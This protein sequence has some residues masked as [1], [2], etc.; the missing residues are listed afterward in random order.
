[1]KVAGTNLSR[2]ARHGLLM[3]GA[4]ALTL[5]AAAAAH[6]QDTAPASEPATEA[7]REVVVTGSRIRGATL[8]SPS[9]LQ[10]VT[11]ETIENAGATNVQ[12]V[13]TQIPAVGVP[14]QTRVSN[15]GDTSPGLSTVNLRNLGDNRTLVLIDGRRSV[16][17][18]PGSSVVDLS[19]IPSSFV[20]R[21]DV[22]TGGASAVY[23]SDAIAGVVNFIYKK[24]FEG[25]HANA[26]SGVSELGDDARFAVNAT[27]GQNFAGDRG[28]VMIYAGFQHE[29][30][31]PN[32][33]RERTARG[34]SSVGNLQRSGTATDN[35]LIAA[36]NL[37]QRFYQPSNVGPGGTF[38]FGGSGS[39]LILPDGTLTA[40][41]AVNG[42]NYNN[43]T[44]MALVE[45][46]GYNAAALAQQASP[47]D[48]LTVATRVNFDVTENLNLFAESTFSNYKTK[49][50]REASPMRTDSALGAF[51]GTGGFFPIQFQV[52]NPANPADVRLLTNPLVPAAVVAA[53]DNRNN[54]DSI[55]SKDIS[56][57]I[58][59]S[60]FG[61]GTRSTPT[62]RDNFRVALGGTLERGG[63]WT[64]DAYYT[65]GYTKQRQS[66]TGLADLNR[67]AQSVQAIPDVFDYDRDGNTTEA[68]CVDANAR[69]QGCVPVNVYGLNADG[70]SKISPEA[71]AYL[72]TELS[73]YSKQE[74]QAAALNIGGTV[75]NL[76]AGPVQVSVGAEWRSE[77]SMDDFDPLTN[78][79][80]N[81]YVQLLDT[82][83]RFN[84]KEAYGEI[85]VPL[86]HDT[87][88]IH[89][90]TFRAAG[91]VS[92]YSTV[93]TFYAWN[94][95]GEWSPIEDIRFRAVYAH[96]VRAPNIGELFA[97]TAAGII[98][99]NDPCQGVTLTS[100]TAASARCRADPGVL[101][102]INT[103]G[104][105]NTFTLTSSDLAGVGSLTASNPD[106]QE[107]T[108]K[109]LTLGVVINPRSISF[110]RG[111][112][113][114]AD[115]F[116]VKLED[117]ISRIDAATVLNKCYIGGLEEFCQFVTRRAQP[118]GAF[119]TG[120]VEQVVRGL[121]NSGGS[122]T[123]GL[124]FTVNYT[125]RV[126]GGQAS[127]SASWTHLLKQGFIPL[128]GDA[129]NNTM[130][131]MGT[132]RDSA[133]LS[134]SWDDDTFGFTVSNEYVGK[135]MF[136]Y[137]NY[138]T[139]F[140]L[141][142]GTLP[143]KKYFTV[144]SKIYTNAQVRL[145]AI[146]NFEFYAG[147]NNLFNVQQPPLWVGTPNGNPNAIW[148]IIGRRY[149]AGARIKF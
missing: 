66:M 29:G 109:T 51:S 140:R 130:G 85:V 95:G 120:S 123:R 54:N 19:M 55:G 59:T 20:E 145:K 74:L 92:D 137:E 83:G 132:P 141:A 14:G 15:A 149:Y 69:A 93:G 75:F 90:L 78:A 2:G 80:R 12:E 111:L 114:T 24:N 16:A 39:R 81:G 56:F 25:L 143:D 89:N 10:A 34:Y 71:A 1:M 31:V 62:E 108:G 77:Y 138:Q 11:S 126:F 50:M 107:E 35:N 112:T 33:N 30:N 82:K 45:R 27:L 63:S 32:T 86:I 128:T 36:Q 115:Y 52:V 119:S 103:P 105:N 136:D 70:T 3:T 142:D 40:Y 38:N 118:S 7:E 53:A 5:L 144:G 98:T 67:L 127:V 106:I 37:F 9:P 131:E 41:P 17:G 99:I 113:I 129:Y 4:S 97:A 22:L 101:A 91:R 46:F 58:R 57:L 68:V 110:L 28:N 64:A 8:T 104:N 121:L 134:V 47:S 135:Q 87:P 79:A 44:T 139:G 6:A 102:N 76:P 125:D 23:G 147:V 72:Q 148:D 88:L 43:P 65:Y 116:D 117:A 96:A 133:N 48:Q 42:T 60:G 124:D 84:V 26:Q 61:D 13:L 49:G 21:V 94:L 100:T 122:F 146:D 18:I 73:R